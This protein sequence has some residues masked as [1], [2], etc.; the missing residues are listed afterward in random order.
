MFGKLCTLIGTLAR[1]DKKMAHGMTRFNVKMRSW[2]AFATLARIPRWH[3]STLARRPRWHIDQVRT[4]GGM[5]RDLAS[6]SCS[7]SLMFIYYWSCSL[8]SYKKYM[9]QL[10][11]PQFLYT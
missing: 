3:A 10:S 1:Q 11:V 7:T 4:Q 8:F 2:H 5:T 6:S 9:P